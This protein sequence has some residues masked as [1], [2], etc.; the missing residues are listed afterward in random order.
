MAGKLL[1]RS[2]N[3]VD[4]CN[5][6]I[7]RGLACPSFVAIGVAN[8]KDIV[9]LAALLEAAGILSL[10][11]MGDAS[12]PGVAGQTLRYSG[13]ILFVQITYTNYYSAATPAV[14]QRGVRAQYYVVE[15]SCRVLPSSSAGNWYGLP[16]RKQRAVYIPSNGAFSLRFADESGILKAVAWPVGRA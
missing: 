14:R 12:G 2:G 4:P 6:Y 3:P 11:A 9:P 8:A 16:R 1:D 7:R 5:A 10:D 13:I 15:C